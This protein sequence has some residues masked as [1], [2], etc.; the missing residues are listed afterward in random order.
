MGAWERRRHTARNC[1]T[2]R[3]VEIFE[4]LKYFSCNHLF[5]HVGDYL[6]ASLHLHPTNRRP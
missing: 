6:N 2:I 1:D 5:L 4:Y 3:A